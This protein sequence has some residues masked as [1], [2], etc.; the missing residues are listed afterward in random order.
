[1]GAVHTVHISTVGVIAAAAAF[2]L[3]GW[4]YWRTD[5]RA[6]TPDGATF[7]SW[8]GLRDLMVKGPTRN[9][10]ILGR[11]R[12]SLVAA[13]A[14][15]ATLIVGP[16]QLSGKSAGILIPALLELDV[17]TLLVTT[18]FPNPAWI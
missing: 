10:L 18:G 14:R 4:V 13:P 16:S 3:V 6:R 9:R 11:Y 12:R 7:A 2:A 17:I 1:M 5:R 8:W 15:A